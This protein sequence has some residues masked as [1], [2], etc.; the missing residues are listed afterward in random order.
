VNVEVEQQVHSYYYSDDDLCDFTAF[1]WA[2]GSGMLLRRKSI[3]APTKDMPNKQAGDQPYITPTALPTF[4]TLS[5]TAS[6]V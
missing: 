1:D 4:S 2:I 6:R 5:V 3:I